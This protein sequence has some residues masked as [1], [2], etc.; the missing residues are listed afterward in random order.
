MKK[1]ELAAVGVNISDDDYW[2]S[3]IQSLPCW[4]ATFIS[5]QLT[6]ARLAGCDVDPELLITFICD[7]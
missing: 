3:I 6:A 2:N 1:A 5:N 4:L 7:K